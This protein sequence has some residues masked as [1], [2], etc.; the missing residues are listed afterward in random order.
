MEDNYGIRPNHSED[1][2]EAIAINPE[3]AE[4][5]RVKPG[6]PVLLIKRVSYYDEKKVEF[7]YRLVNSKLFKYHMSLR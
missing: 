1:N 5:M 6:S 2:I 4:K 7:N 3:D